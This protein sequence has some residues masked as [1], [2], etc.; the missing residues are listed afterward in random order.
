[1][2]I[3]VIDDEKN[4]VNIVS[5][6]LRNVG[7]EVIG[8]LSGEEAIDKII[9]D[10]NIDLI[11]LDIR[12]PDM[13]GYEVLREIREISDAPVIFLTALSESY[14]EAKGLNLGAVDYITKPFNYTVLL[15]RVKAALRIREME[16]SREVSIGELN[17]NMTKREVSIKGKSLKLS[18]KEYEILAYLLNNENKLVGRQTILDRIWGYDYEGDQGTLNT[19]IKT[20]RNKLGD[21][22]RI[23]VTVRGAGYRFEK[24]DK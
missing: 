24:L 8:A 12:M 6:F 3:I 15:A 2:K 19:H 1:M 10:N 13:D 22:G 17:I 7:Y 23:I 5:D 20:L 18:Q 21:Y 14:N 16:N 4:I 9:E 11:L